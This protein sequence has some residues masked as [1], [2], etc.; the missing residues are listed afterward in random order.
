[1]ILFQLQRVESPLVG[2]FFER[3]VDVECVFSKYLEELDEPISKDELADW[4][5]DINLFMKGLNYP[6]KLEALWE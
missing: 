6:D 3:S 2:K 4:S 5:H 1:M